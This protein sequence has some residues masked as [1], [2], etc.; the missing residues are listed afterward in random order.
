MSLVLAKKGNIKCTA[1]AGELQLDSSRILCH[2]L[3]IQLNQTLKGL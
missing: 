2:N 3:A 1:A